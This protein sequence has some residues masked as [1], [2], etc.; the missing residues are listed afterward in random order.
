MSRSY[1][2]VPGYCD[3]SPGDK[4][5]ANVTV[6]RYKGDPQD[7]GWYKKLYESWNIC[8][9]RFVYYPMGRSYSYTRHD[10][11]GPFR[12]YGWSA[13]GENDPVH[14]RKARSK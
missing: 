13:S 9:Y 6:R 8:D 7:G 1:K 3:H 4:R 10:R 5:Q 11:P 12:P 2:K 14:M